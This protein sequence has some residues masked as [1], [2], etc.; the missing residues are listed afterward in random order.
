MVRQRGNRHSQLPP[1]YL[2][3]DCRAGKCDAC[4]DTIVPSVRSGRMPR[5]CHCDHAHKGEPMTTTV[6]A[7]TSVFR[8]TGL[9]SFRGRARPRK[10]KDA[11]TDS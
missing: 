6:P 5:M 1:K 11:N 2:C 8:P 10:I 9:A 3:I 4:I 7:A